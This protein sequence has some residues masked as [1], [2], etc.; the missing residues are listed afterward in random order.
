MSL[1]R[2]MKCRMSVMTAKAAVVD[3]AGAY[4]REVAW[5]NLF[6]DAN[7]LEFENIRSNLQSW[8][9]GPNVVMAAGIKEEEIEY[10]V[11]HQHVSLY[12]TLNSD[13]SAG[14]LILFNKDPT[15]LITDRTDK[16]QINTFEYLGKAELVTHLRGRKNLFEMFLRLNN[17]FF[18]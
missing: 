8:K 15:K 14:F 12:D 4:D 17:I 9:R 5:S 2:L 3:S 18:Q 1:R 7:G 6:K 16:D 10:Q 13:P 11:F